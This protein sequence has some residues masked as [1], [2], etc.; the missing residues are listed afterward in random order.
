[1]ISADAKIFINKMLEINVNKRL[2]ASEALND[3]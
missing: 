2:S 3:S 1:M